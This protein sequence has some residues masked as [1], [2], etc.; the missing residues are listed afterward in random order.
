MF[1]IKVVENVKTRVLY[2][3]TFFRKSCCLRD[4]V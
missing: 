3:I 1:Q 4:I 2:S